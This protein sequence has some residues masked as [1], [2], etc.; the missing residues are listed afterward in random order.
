M[1]SKFGDGGTLKEPEKNAFLKMMKAHQVLEYKTERYLVLRS[2]LLNGAFYMSFFSLSLGGFFFKQ[3]SNSQFVMLMALMDQIRGPLNTL[4]QSIIKIQS[5]YI[6]SIQL[7][8]EVGLAEEC[9]R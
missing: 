5:A 3:Y 9:C 6:N 4:E 2:S 7:L 8:G 1:L